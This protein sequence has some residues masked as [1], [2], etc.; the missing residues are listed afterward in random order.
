MNEEM[1]KMLLTKALNDYNNG[2]RVT[3]NDCIQVVLESLTIHREGA[4]KTNL[5]KYF[6]EMIEIDKIQLQELLK[7]KNT[8]QCQN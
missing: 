7:I 1:R 6:K 3:I 4:K 8:K 2:I 5:K